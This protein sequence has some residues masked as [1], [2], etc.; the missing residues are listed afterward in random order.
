MRLVYCFLF[1]LDK[2]HVL[3][4]LS[5]FL[6]HMDFLSCAQCE[7]LFEGQTC[8]CL[9]EQSNES[10]TP[11]CQLV[12]LH[13]EEQALT[14]VT[15]KEVARHL[16]PTNP[17][18]INAVSSHHSHIATRICILN[19]QVVQCVYIHVYLSGI[20]YHTSDK[21]MHYGTV[22]W[23]LVLSQTQCSKPT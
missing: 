16:D 19:F 15:L 2:V 22:L 18:K 6:P 4:K 5:Q 1:W 10:S 8:N 12:L 23:C 9:N 7:H 13:I 14:Q 21:C 17:T 20:K 11:G 3:F